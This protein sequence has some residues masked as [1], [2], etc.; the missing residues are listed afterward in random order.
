MFE[1]VGQKNYRTYFKVLRSL[2][3]DGG[4]FLLHTIGTGTGDYSSDRWIEKYI[5]PNGVL[6]PPRGIVDNCDGLFT[7]EDWHNI[8]ADYD[9]TLMAW[10]RNFN[11]AWSELKD[12][13]SDRFKRMFDYYLLT[14][15]GSFRARDNQLWQVVLSADGIEGGYRADRWLTSGVKS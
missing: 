8:G 3:S 7:I 1:H 9:P 12:R 2:L 10:Y 14:C 4:I 5:F 15:A 13:Y 11:D 6:P